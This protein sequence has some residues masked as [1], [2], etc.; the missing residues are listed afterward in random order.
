[1]AFTLYIG[2]T[3]LIIQ[4]IDLRAIASHAAATDPEMMAIQESIDGSGNY[5]VIAPADYAAAALPANF[6]FKRRAGE[7]SQVRALVRR[8]GHSVEA[9]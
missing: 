1:M 3:G 8:H 4:S 6:D 9:P 2:V 5:E 7:R